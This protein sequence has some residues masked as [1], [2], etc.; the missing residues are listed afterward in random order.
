MMS[1]D[2]SE[3]SAVSLRVTEG[4]GAGFRGLQLCDVLGTD[5]RLS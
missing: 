3:L 2:G 5:L 4:S 1:K